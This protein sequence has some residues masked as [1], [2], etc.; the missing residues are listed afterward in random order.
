MKVSYFVKKAKKVT[1][2]NIKEKRINGMLNVKHYVSI[3]KKID[4][5]DNVVKAATTERDKDG[6]V[7]GF[8]VNSLTKYLLHVL[9]LIGLYTDLEID[10]SNAIE[11]YDLLNSNDFISMII[12]Q[13]GESEIAECQLCLDMVWNDVIQNTLSPQA[14]IKEQVTRFG[15]L[16]GATISPMIE[17]LTKAVEGL[18]D[19]K[20]KAI[21]EAIGK[22]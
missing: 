19:E 3:A 7:I 10:Y 4:L 6:N 20:V 2:D 13:I 17:G 12:R 22:R 14:F 15:T 5:A 18:D 21:V 9:G 11:E 1:N 8:K 16:A